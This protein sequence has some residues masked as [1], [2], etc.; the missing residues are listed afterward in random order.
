MSAQAVKLPAIF[1]GIQSKVDRSY[2]LTFLTRELHGEDAA[3][4]LKFNQ[5]ECWLLVA[6]TE[7]AI[8]SV[9]VPDYKPET[10]TVTKTPSQRLR[11][12]LFVAW[13]QAGEPGNGFEDYYGWQME[14]ILDSIK[15]KLDGGEA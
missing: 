9:D 2:K 7:D 3:V 12:C 6:P 10:G 14:R 8:D 13:K 1:A 15:Q 11:A 4:L 5:S